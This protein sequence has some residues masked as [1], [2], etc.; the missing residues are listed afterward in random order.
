MASRNY[1]RAQVAAYGGTYNQQIRSGH[2]QMQYLMNAYRPPLISSDFFGTNRSKSFGLYVVVPEGYQYALESF[3]VYSG[4]L[5]AG[6][7]FLKPFVDQITF[8]RCLKSG[9]LDCPPQHVVSQDNVSLAVDGAIII[10]TVDTYKSCY[11]VC[12]PEVCLINLA[13]GII[14]KTIGGMHVDELLNARERINKAVLSEMT[15]CKD[16]WGIEVVSY[17]VQN[18]VVNNEL[19]NAMHAQS[20]AERQKRARIIESEGERT[21]IQNYS[22]GKRQSDINQ[23]EGARQQAINMAEGL[24]QRSVI[25]AQANAA[26][27][28]TLAKA[29]SDAIKKFTSA[30]VPADEASLLY[31]T[32]KYEE[33]M[34]SMLLNRGAGNSIIIA[35]NLTDLSS[36]AAFADKAMKGLSAQQLGLLHNANGVSSTSSAMMVGTQLK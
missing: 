2:D 8:T 29:H 12:Q 10:R 22:E 25:E 7:H 3:G 34:P 4:M 26:A 24:Y 18:I 31:L 14:R 35:E 30:G 15:F 13:N 1:N 6:I 5:D 16:Q 36:P 23:S 32:L 27:A 28:T 17:E 19:A 11:N 21:S 33:Q 20:G 9:L